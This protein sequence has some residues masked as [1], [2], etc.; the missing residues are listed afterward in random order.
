[1]DAAR[2]SRGRYQAAQI[3]AVIREGTS[4]VVLGRAPPLLTRSTTLTRGQAGEIHNSIVV[5]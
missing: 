4:I 1:M 3:K 5:L 2:G